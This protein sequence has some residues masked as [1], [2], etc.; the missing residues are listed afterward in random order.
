MGETEESKPKKGLNEWVKSQHLNNFI[1]VIVNVLIL[2]GLVL[3]WVGD[4]LNNLILTLQLFLLMFF[5]TVPLIV[6]RDVIT[7]SQ[8]A[9]LQG[10]WE[11]KDTDS[12][13][14]SE[15]QK[16]IW[17]RIAP[18]AL[19]FGGLAG[20]LGYLAFWIVSLVS[21]S[22]TLAIS[23]TIVLLIAA[24]IAFFPTWFLTRTWIKRHLNPVLSDFAADMS[25]PKPTEPVPFK[26]YFLL[27]HTLPW[28][29]ILGIMNI[30]INWKSFQEKALLTSGITL[31]HVAEAVFYTTLVLVIWMFLSANDQV[32][33][34]VHLGRVKEGRPLKGW[35]V[36]LL[37]IIAPVIGYGLILLFDI[38]LSV[39]FTS[40][41]STVIIVINAVISV[42]LGRWLGIMW[43]KTDEFRKIQSK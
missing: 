32:R 15:T 31:T 6:L 41:L 34:D 38:L 14:K 23:P 33:P 10:K 4:A 20:V 22:D 35:I 26:R 30:G 11:I 16:T 24:L 27:E 12:T 7:D 18:E 17:R 42:V 39:I 40:I 8:N 19:L 21:A 25:G 9:Y 37:F 2:P 36:I 28:A 29:I 43:G 13:S 5:T 1:K 3:W